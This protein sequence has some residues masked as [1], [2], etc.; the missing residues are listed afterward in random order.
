MI[1]VTSSH[2]F[3]RFSRQYWKIDGVY[4]QDLSSNPAPS[5][6]TNVTSKED[7]S[8]RDFR[9][10]I[11]NGENATTP[12]MFSGKEI[13]GKL[14]SIY[15]RQR[16]I[17]PT[18]TDNVREYGNDGHLLFVAPFAGTSGLP[19][20]TA[21]N[22]ALSRFY[23]NL[24]SVETKFK[25]LVFAG[26]L[27]ESLRMIRHP[28]RALRNGISNYLNQIKRFGRIK[29][30]H[31]VSAIR[32]TWLE[33][34]FGWRPLISD[35]DGALT[36]FYTSDS[37]RPIFEMVR[38]RGE[39]ERA[40]RWDNFIYSP[41]PTS[42]LYVDITQ[43]ERTS[44]KVYGIYRSL[45]RGSEDNHH[46]GFRPSE[47]VP[48]LWE[49]IPYSFLVDYFTNIGKI[50]ESWSYRFIAVNFASQTVFQELERVFEN[51]RFFWAAEPGFKDEELKVSLG[52]SR[53]SNKSIGRTPSID[54]S[55]P[56]LELKVPGN[57]VQWINIAA[58]SAGLKSSRAV[59]SR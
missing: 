21:R 57:W 29:K 13:E 22:Q 20:S 15:R 44:V 3:R 54:L 55:V 1:D 5:S 24:N 8:G 18:L 37:V 9:R 16:R 58:L 32:A 51:P 12:L 36:A 23:S 50:L 52:L 14:S 26:E 4:V 31:R 40:T 10:L 30:K 56:S 47:F 7:S 28:A 41:I 19:I 42:T 34:S 25:G 39:L 48:T 11:S 2:S 33:A 17:Q 59:L 45:G 46:Y 53:A 35:L 43:Y 6:W 49:L 38:G 27:R